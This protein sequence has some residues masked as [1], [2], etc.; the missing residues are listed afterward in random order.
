MRCFFM[1][2]CLW[3]EH[4]ALIWAV[5]SW[6][7]LELWRCRK[8]RA[9]EHHR[10]Q[11]YFCGQIV[12]EKRLEWSSSNPADAISFDKENTKTLYFAL[13]VGNCVL[14]VLHKNMDLFGRALAR[15]SAGGHT[16]FFKN[17]WHFSK[18]VAV[19]SEQLFFSTASRLRKNTMSSEVKN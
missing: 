9:C 14:L 1:K 6:K 11:R 4:T 5:W 19:S 7:I 18:R 3:V 2:K 12:R 16:L 13:C 15:A 8:D 10:L 17:M